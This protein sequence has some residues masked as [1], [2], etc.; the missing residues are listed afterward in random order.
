MNATTQRFGVLL[1]ACAAIVSACG[2]PAE[3]GSQPAR[4]ADVAVQAVPA[5]IAPSYEVAIAIAAADRNRAL[6]ECE[7]LPEKERASCRDDAARRFDATRA[8]LQDSRGD[9]P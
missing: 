9:Q 2:G 7:S 3:Q 4:S 8:G 5:K 1:A 6:G